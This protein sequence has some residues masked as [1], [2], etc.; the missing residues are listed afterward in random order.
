M[1]ISHRGAV[2]RLGAGT[3]QRASAAAESRVL[4]L[5][6]GDL[7]VVGLYLPFKAYGPKRAA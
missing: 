2:R 6:E 4:M 7:F 1:A 3:C 5:L